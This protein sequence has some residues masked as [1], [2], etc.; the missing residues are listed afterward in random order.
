MKMLLTC[1][2]TFF[3]GGKCQICISHKQIYESLQRVC[4]LYMAVLSKTHMFK[5]M[6]YVDY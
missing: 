2:L 5:Q 6:A 3:W 4:L 1:N